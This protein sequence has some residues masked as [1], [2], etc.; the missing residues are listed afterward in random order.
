[1][2]ARKL[3][4]QHEAN[5]VHLE[6]TSQVTLTTQPRSIQEKRPKFPQYARD[7]RLKICRAQIRC[8]WVHVT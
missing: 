3:E 7:Y 8:I 1:M 4:N 5:V 6:P 2:I